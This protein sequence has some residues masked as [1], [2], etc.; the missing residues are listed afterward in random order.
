MAANFVNLED[1]DM[2]KIHVCEMNLQRGGLK[3]KKYIFEFIRQYF[4]SAAKGKGGLM[5]LVCILIQVSVLYMYSTV[6]Y[7]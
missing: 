4:I 5:Y 2:K 6:Q 3:Q 7:K 1:H